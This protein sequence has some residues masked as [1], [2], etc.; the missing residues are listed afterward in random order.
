M[1][2]TATT[3]FRAIVFDFDGTAIPNSATGMPSRRLIQAVDA[4]RTRIHLIGATG[5]PISY[6]APIFEA[7]GLT[8]PCVISGGTIIIDPATKHIVRRTTIAPSTVSA[9]YKILQQYPYRIALSEHGDHENAV[10]GH[11]SHDD[12]DI[13]YVGGVTHTHMLSMKAKIELLPGITFMTAPSWGDKG[14]YVIHIVNHAATKE[15]AISEVLTNLGVNQEQAIGVG[16]GD[17]DLHLFAAVGHKVAM[18]NAG[19]NLKA[20]A[21]EIAPTQDHDG[22]AYII[23]KYTRKLPGA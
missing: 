16:D 23:D 4:A 1:S 6:A 12:V 17:N 3:D 2:K 13:I 8:D 7:L 11:T 19:P 9:I 15:H 21:D 22:L 5:R 14:T 18:G 20:A 10:A